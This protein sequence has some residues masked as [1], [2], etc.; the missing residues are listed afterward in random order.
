MSAKPLKV[1]LYWHMH[2]PEYRDLR[3]GKYH[4][5]WTYLHGIKDYVDMAAHLEA[6][7][8]ARAV[9]NF[10]PILLEQIDDY[11][12]QIK[13]FLNNSTA[14][15]DPLLAALAGPV[16][17]SSQESRLELIRHCLRANAERLIDPF[18]AYRKLA[19]IALW[20]P[21]HPDMMLYVNDQYLADLLVWYHLA[22]I[23]ET[24]RR[25]DRRIKQLLE[26]ASGYTL[27]DRRELLAIMGE[28]LAGITGR[29]MAL[30]K[31]GQVELSMTPYAH[32]IMPLLLDIQ[33]AEEALPDISLPFLQHYPGGEER[34]RW[35]L[36]EGLASFEK[37]FGIRPVGC[38]PSEGS[39]SEASL[40]LL[41]EAGFKWTASGE[42]VLR[43]SLAASDM[44]PG[45]DSCI[46][47]RYQLKNQAINC[48]F[49]DDGLSDLIGFTYSDWH[50]DDA[51]AN[52]VHHLED[53]ANACTDQDGSV[54]SIILDGENAWEFY[55]DN[56]YYFLRALYK[57]IAEHPR[58]QLT[59]FSD[60]LNDTE[61]VVIPKL[62]A[63]SWVY[64]TFSTWIG[65]K[66]KN[67]AWDMLG[68]AKR[69]YDKV[70]ASDQ[71]DEQHRQR[72]A[73]QLAICEGSD[74]FWW[75]GDYN[76]AESVSDFESLYRMHLS[77]LYQILGQ[78][79]PAYLSEVFAHGSGSPALGGAMRK[80]QE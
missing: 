36:Q 63:G 19:D 17:P 54:V 50:A 45:P 68:E 40:K 57:G 80:G 30:A 6:I 70:M 60:C 73:R 12:Q 77:N 71:L 58:L 16:L 27:H 66:D 14:L 31:R 7:P 46:H 2:Q 3:S 25:E 11:A 21:Q 75:F 49:R 51:V 20:L 38:W 23:G 72:A 5:P 59:T 67:R 42:S 56:G 53:I 74:W 24:V 76:S 4:Q 41:S 32:P 13:G 44:V 47:Q 9:V 34:V 28:L 10:V 62:V 26:K 48:F 35:H 52:F 61:S 39:V 37:Y 64:G 55:P 69:N 33:S 43:N 22:W 8:E 18:P 29:Y 65:D 15:S 79:P 78:E 1:V